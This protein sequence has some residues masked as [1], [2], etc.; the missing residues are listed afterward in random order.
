[1]ANIEEVRADITR[2]VDIAE[3]L[4]GALD[5][6]HNMLEEAQMAVDRATA[7]SGQADVGEGQQPVQASH[8]ECYRCATGRVGSHPG[9]RGYCKSVVKLGWSAVTTTR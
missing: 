9:F 6:A 3:K 8:P 2:A 4:R 5:E 7:G 1:M